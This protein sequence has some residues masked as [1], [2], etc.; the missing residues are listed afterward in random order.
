MRRFK[1][2]LCKLA[3]R[4]LDFPPPP[5]AGI[6]NFRV[7]AFRAD[8][9]LGSPLVRMKFA[10]GSCAGEVVLTPEGTRA[11]VV[12]LGMALD[13]LDGKDIRP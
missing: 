7:H 8:E 12:K 4:A 11:L 5:R 3:L 1:E 6:T 13:Y 10:D 9:A 2:W